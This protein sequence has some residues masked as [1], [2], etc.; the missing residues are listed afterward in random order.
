MNDIQ[1]AQAARILSC[2]NETPETLLEKGG[3]GSKGGKIIGHTRSGKPIYDTYGHSAHRDFTAQDHKDASIVN[4][5]EASKHPE[6]SSEKKNHSV[7]SFYHSIAIESAPS[8]QRKREGKGGSTK[9]ATKTKEFYEKHKDK[10]KSHLE[11]HSM[12]NYSAS[13]AAEKAGY[14]EDDA[15][16]ADGTAHGDYADSRAGDYKSY[17][18]HHDEIHENIGDKMS[19]Y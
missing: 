19:K 18:K 3:E 14:N 5:N 1:K 13:E 6:E 11:D 8:E 10:I 7:N 12:I 17:K 9:E 16:E 2:Y 15:E 4:K